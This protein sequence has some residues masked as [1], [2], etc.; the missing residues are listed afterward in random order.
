[1][2]A[3]AIITVYT[4]AICNHHSVASRE[5]FI[6]TIVLLSKEVEANLQNTKDDVSVCV[7]FIRK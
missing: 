7:H 5:E 6:G 1:L 2:L 4:I 3:R